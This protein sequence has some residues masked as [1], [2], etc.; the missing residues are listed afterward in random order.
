VLSRS[1][2][3]ALL[4]SGA[5][6][7]NRKTRCVFPGCGAVFTSA[8][9]LVPDD[10]FKDKME[11]FYRRFEQASQFAKSNRINEGEELDDDDEDDDDDHAAD[12]KVQ[13]K[14]SIKDERKST[15]G[16]RR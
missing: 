5:K 6:D 3:I 10:V 11:R 14:Q 2:W 13:Q 8:A 15:G 7:K 16:R 1:S 4:A 12:A 9:D